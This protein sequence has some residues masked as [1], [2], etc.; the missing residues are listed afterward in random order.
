MSRQ[1]RIKNWLIGFALGTLCCLVLLFVCFFAVGCTQN[2]QMNVSANKEHA[3]TWVQDTLPGY[4]LVGFT[5]AT[6]DTD[7]DGYVSCDIMVKKESTGEMRLI[8]LNCPTA[9]TDMGQVQIGGGCKYKE[10]PFDSKF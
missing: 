9:S 7:N 5:T 2:Q 4:V 3:K 6:L 1:T 10:M 8:S